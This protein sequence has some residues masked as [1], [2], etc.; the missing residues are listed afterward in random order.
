MGHVLQM[1]T[2]KVAAVGQVTNPSDRLCDLCNEAPGIGDGPK[3]L[4]Q[5]CAIALVRTAF[6]ILKPKVTAVGTVTNP[7]E[8]V[9]P[10]GQ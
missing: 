5:P 7:P 1:P 8:G 3:V 6:A 10:H 4:C 9:A 2:P